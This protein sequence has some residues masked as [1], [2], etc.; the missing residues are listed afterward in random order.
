MQIVILQSDGGLKCSVLTCF[1]NVLSSLL[2]HAA[3]L[4]KKHKDC[5]HGV[6]QKRVRLTSKL[7]GRCG[8][9][10]HQSGFKIA[11]LAVV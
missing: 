9:W 6:G 7:R 8:K 10:S 11:H 1:E 3:H 5:D 2:V 4:Q